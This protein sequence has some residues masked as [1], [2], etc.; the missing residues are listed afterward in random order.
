MRKLFFRKVDYF[1]YNFL[2]VHIGCDTSN[3]DETPIALF[4]S[5]FDLMTCFAI[6]FF[7]EICNMVVVDNYIFVY[8]QIVWPMIQRL[9]FGSASSD[10][11]F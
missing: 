9:A 2:R 10:F 3:S 5:A 11:R 7:L 8:V 6:L 4:F 1:T